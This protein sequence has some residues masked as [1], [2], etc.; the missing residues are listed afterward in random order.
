MWM[1]AGVDDAFGPNRKS[2]AIDDR[3]DPSDHHTRTPSHP[4]LLAEPVCVVGSSDLCDGRTFFGHQSMHR[5]VSAVLPLNPRAHDNSTHN[6]SRLAPGTVFEGV[7]CLVRPPLINRRPP[8]PRPP[9]A[10]SSGRGMQAGGAGGRGDAMP[11]YV[12]SGTGPVGRLPASA[13]PLFGR[14]EN[15]QP[16]VDGSRAF[17]GPGACLPNHDALAA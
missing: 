7:C 17:A 2:Y 12:G 9:T 16:A 5:S 14:M 11:I 4:L 6:Q 13:M 8:A 3:L 15:H 1:A 10:R